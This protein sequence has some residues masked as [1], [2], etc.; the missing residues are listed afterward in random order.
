LR[1][2]HALK[3]A[4][5]RRSLSKHTAALLARAL[6]RQRGCSR[7][8]P[9][10]ALLRAP[11][12][13]THPHARK[14]SGACTM[15]QSDARDAATLVAK[16]RASSSSTN[17]QADCCEA[18]RGLT[19]E[20]DAAADAIDAIVAA[21]RRGADKA[22]LQQSG[23]SALS[24]LMRSSEDNRITAAAAGAIEA[25]VG[26]LRAR[27]GI[28]GVQADGCEALMHMFQGSAHV[29]VA[30]GAA[31]AVEVILTAL[32]RHPTNADVQF[33]GWLALGNITVGDAES[34]A[35]AAAAG[36]FE[37]AVAALDRRP[38]QQALVVSGAC[39]ALGALSG[40]CAEYATKAGTAG[41]VKAVV[42]ALRLFPDDM[43]VQ[44]DGC[45]ALAAMLRTAENR[46]RAFNSGAG[47]T[48][49]AA[50]RAYAAE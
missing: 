45:V 26:G 47:E 48:I 13:H 44:R 28:A 31:S 5:A 1:T 40:R 16:L 2:T 33:C 24:G 35:S 36:A 19:L 3:H 39:Y 34:A 42:A 10:P 41:A 17:T 49:I 4:R 37:T 50:M 27:P 9:W 29:C 18:L 32:R 43:P 20:G 6:Q 38:A 30:V 8:P 22:T 21:L 11:A 15:Q 23:F 46:R 25:I 12:D 7:V 14:P